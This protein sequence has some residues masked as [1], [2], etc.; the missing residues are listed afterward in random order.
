MPIYNKLVRDRI[1]YIIKEKGKRAKVSILTEKDYFNELRK[2]AKE[3][4]DEYLNAVTNE[5]A[6]EEL[7]DL[8]EVMHGLVKIH[9]SSMEEVEA[10]R[11]R[12]A[13]DR[14]A[15]EDRVFLIE[16]EDFD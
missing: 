3:E 6:L 2:K 11:K 5:A 16:V 13:I 1:P 10:I 7:A 8:L 12:K 9:S 15:F 4:L 14:G